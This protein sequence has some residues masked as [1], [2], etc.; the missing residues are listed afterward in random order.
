MTDVNQAAQNAQAILA[1]LHAINPDFHVMRR[2]LIVEMKTRAAAAG[3]KLTNKQRVVL[4][5]MVRAYLAT[6]KS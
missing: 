4:T 5:E 6:V 3:V 2:G 1:Q